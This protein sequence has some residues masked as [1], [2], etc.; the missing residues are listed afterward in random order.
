MASIPE[1]IDKIIETRKTR[2][3]ELRSLR[4]QSLTAYAAVKDFAR[5]QNELKNRYNELALN[6]KEGLEDRI[7]SISTNDFFDCYDE[8]EKKLETLI[9]RLNRDNL[10]ISFIGKAGQGKSLLMQRI[11]GLSGS[12]IPSAEG[13]DCTGAKSIIT[14]VDSPEVSA[15]IVFF[16]EKE[17]ID[18]VNRVC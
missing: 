15:T 16:T 9:D 12:V 8:Y 4:D 3:S 18:I 11:S 13:D 2:V 1:Q 6:D 10:H 17:M 14:N 5:M 7:V